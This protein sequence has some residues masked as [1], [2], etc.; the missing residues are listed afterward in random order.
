MKINTEGEYERASKRADEI[1]EA[2][3]GTPEKE[4]LKELLKDLKEYEDDF[5]QF[6]KLHG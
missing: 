3:E 6:L 1:F 4:E 5:V 2:K